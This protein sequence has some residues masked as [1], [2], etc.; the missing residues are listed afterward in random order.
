LA[1]FAAVVWRLLDRYQPAIVL[2][3][4]TFLWLAV[5]G[6]GWTIRRTRKFRADVESSLFN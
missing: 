6:M 4:A 1:A 5:S 2:A 3:A